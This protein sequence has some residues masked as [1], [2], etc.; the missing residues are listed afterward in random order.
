MTGFVAGRELTPAQHAA[1]RRQLALIPLYVWIVYAW[2]LFALHL[3]VGPFATTSHVTRDFV[4]FYAQAVIA[5]EHDAHALYDID[6]MAAVVDRV[7]P[8]PVENRFPPVYGPQVALLLLPLSLLSYVPAMML[9]LGIT[10]ALYAACVI[11]VWRRQAALRQQKWLVTMLALGGVGLHFTLSFGQISPIGLACVTALWL[12]L[13]RGRM[14]AA[15]L[16]VGALAY[17]PPLGI[18]AACVFVAAGEWRVVAGAVASI[19]AQIGAALA[20]WGPSVFGGYLSALR[21]LPAVMD[22][23]EPDKDL[24]HSWRAMFVHLGLAGSTATALAIVTSGFTIAAIIVLWRRKG[25]LE[26]RYAALIVA[27]LMVNPHTYAYDLLLLAPALL[28]AWGW[29]STGDAHDRTR[30]QWALGFLYV[31]PIVTIAAPAVPIQWSVAAGTAFVVCC[32]LV[33]REIE[34]KQG[35]SSQRC[36]N[37]SHKFDKSSI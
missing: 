34:Q 19:V 16:A 9:W 18:V 14:F 5:R 10:I 25:P 8:L 22:A 36:Q 21:K 32:L 2:S 17:K 7:V 3:P 27:T 29:T 13:R 31:A 6:A 33:A 20:Y 35:S 1:I 23:M 37:P 11:A 15:G 4:H 12:A 26:L 30:I 28:V 24:M